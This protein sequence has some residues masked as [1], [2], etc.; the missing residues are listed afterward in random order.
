MI[1]LAITLGDLNGI[2]PEIAL[3]AVFG[4]RRNVPAQF[5]FVGDGVALNA[6]AR[7][8]G[9]P[10]VPRW[11]PGE[12]I[13]RGCRA[14]VWAPAGV[15]APVYAPGHCTAD[16]SRAAVEWIRSAVSAA[17]S[18][19]V[20]ALV[21]A[22]ICKEGLK[23]A[24]IDLPGHTEFLAQLTGCR[25]YAMMLMG[26]PLRVIL[27]TR[28]LPLAE[29]PRHITVRAVREAATLAEEG[30]RWMGIEAPRI[31]ICG[32]NPHAGDGGALG[33][34]ERRII[35][36]AVRGLQR[37]GLHAQGPI[38]ADVIFYQTVQGRFDAV[39]AMYHDQGLA[40]LKMIAF[41]DGIN[42]TLGLPIIRT[43]PDHGTAFDIAG[44]DCAN[45]SSMKAA[46][47]LAIDL[48]GRKNPWAGKGKR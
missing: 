29:V 1:R 37:A 2:G 4:C 46:I 13:P 36:P 16:A 10:V 47:N 31:G 15:R 8:Y 18:G 44:K 25:R 34:E 6:L 20:D 9:Y 32:L 14:V 11:T 21:T 23:K 27:A 28:H 30:L 42:L 22:P 19:L 17:Q 5:V 35:A 48:A 40:P 12:V 24:H 45:P 38:P 43:S 33:S 39:V 26:G 7:T 3:K 41:E